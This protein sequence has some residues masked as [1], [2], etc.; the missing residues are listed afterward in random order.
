[1]RFAELDECQ[2]G[3][4]RFGKRAMSFVLA[5]DAPLS[6]DAWNPTTDAA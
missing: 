2:A 4:C 6:H 5:R 3:N 1:V